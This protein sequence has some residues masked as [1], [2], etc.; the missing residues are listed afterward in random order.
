[1]PFLLRTLRILV[2]SENS[3]QGA[4]TAQLFISLSLLLMNVLKFHLSLSLASMTQSAI[5]SH[6]E[7]RQL[8]MEE[9]VP[10]MT[11]LNTTLMT[12]TMTTLDLKVVT[13]TMKKKKK[14]LLMTTQ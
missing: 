10:M 5:T 11:P 7:E 4:E 8:R 9:N 14:Y 12:L 6:A 2:S 1:M 13:L 3:R